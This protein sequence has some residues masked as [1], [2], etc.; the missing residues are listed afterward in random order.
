[1]SHV[2]LHADNQAVTTSVP[3]AFIDRYMID[4]SGEFVKIYLYLLRCIHGNKNEM[5]ISKIADKFDHTE[6]DVKR[7]LKYWEKVKLLRL[8]YD[9]EGSLNRICVLDSKANEPAPKPKEHCFELSAEPSSLPCACEDASEAQSLTSLPSAC[10]E[11]KFYSL[12]EVEAFRSQDSIRTLFFIAERYMCHPLTTNDVQTILYWYDSLHF[13]CE[14]IE[15]L[16]EYCVD[17]SHPNTR[18]MDKVALSWA[19]MNIETVEQA[20]Q[21]TNIHNQAYYTVMKHFGITN[22]SLVP[23]E[24]DYIERWIKE[25]GFSLDIITEACKRTIQ[26]IHQ[27]GFEYA[28]RILQSWKENNIHHLDDIAILDEHYKSSKRAASASPK[29]NTK[30]NTKFNNF[31]QRNY[32]YE[33][34]EQQ[35]LKGSM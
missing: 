14:L 28:D 3:N 15:Y 25:Y 16:I 33:Q 11:R 34:L 22:R 27:P 12:N 29:T 18:Y 24:I 2:I 5:S 1:M 7:A 6:K 20:K 31:S 26:A 13:S 9:E 10:E 30:N 4:A 32:N 8:D 19:D 35:L 23:Y 17:K 21:V